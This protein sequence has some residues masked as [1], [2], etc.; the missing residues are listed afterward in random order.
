MPVRQVWPVRV[1][2]AVLCVW[3]VGWCSPLLVLLRSCTR[4]RLAPG[5]VPE[6]AAGWV[7]K[8]HLLV[9]LL[10]PLRNVALLWAGAWPSVV[11]QGVMVE[12]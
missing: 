3:V 7:L 2:C 11:S 1:P 6:R 5:S 4:R 12:L 9:E 8:V 10:M